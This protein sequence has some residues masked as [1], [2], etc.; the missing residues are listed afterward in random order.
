VGANFAFL[1]DGFGS[2]IA[3]APCVKV[4][5]FG[6]ADEPR[7]EILTYYATSR[8]ARTQSGWRPLALRA[9]N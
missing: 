7:Y 8:L 4:E 9:Y 3:E 6:G 1:Q 2:A 5:S